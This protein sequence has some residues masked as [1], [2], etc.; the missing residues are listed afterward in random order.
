M[1]LTRVN[2]GLMAM[3]FAGPVRTVVGRAAS[4]EEWYLTDVVDAA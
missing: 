3:L 4:E 2:L 1:S